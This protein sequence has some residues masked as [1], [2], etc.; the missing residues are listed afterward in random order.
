MA[1][2]LHISYPEGIELL[3]PARITVVGQHGG[4]FPIGGGPAGTGV[5]V[6]DATI[7]AELDGFPF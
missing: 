4:T 5:L 6:Y 7:Y 2:V 1:S 3:K